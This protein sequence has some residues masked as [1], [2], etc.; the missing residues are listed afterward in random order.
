LIKNEYGEIVS[1]EGMLEVITARACTLKN[2]PLGGG[3][4][5][6]PNGLI[7]HL[8][9]GRFCVGHGEGTWDLING[10]FS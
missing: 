9:D 4:E 6:G 2:R 3:Y 8:I 10:E 1:P 5:E 7:R